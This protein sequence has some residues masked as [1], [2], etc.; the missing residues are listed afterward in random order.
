MQTETVF[1]K[2]NKFNTINLTKMTNDINKENAL[3]QVGSNSLVSASYAIEITKKLLKND[4]E[5]VIDK[6]IKQL[7]EEEINQ[8]QNLLNV[9]TKQITSKETKKK[10]TKEKLILLM[11]KYKAKALAEKM[12]K[13]K[14]TLKHK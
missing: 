12:Q 2:R 4:L 1:E 14:Q 8:K 6:T 10:L 9:G 13:E 3:I 5:T 7:T 11:N